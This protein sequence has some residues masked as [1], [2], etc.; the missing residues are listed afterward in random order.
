MNAIAVILL[1]FSL[2]GALDRIIGN[3]FG[4]GKEFEK[5]FDLMGSLCLSM[6]GM[7]VM[8][9]WLAQ[10]LEPALQWIWNHLKIDP[11]MIT[12]MIF[13]GDCGGAP[14]ATEVAMDPQM[15]RFTGLVVSS[16]MGMTI[17][18][19]IAFG[20]TVV[21]PDRHEPMLLGML[22]GVLTIPVGCIVAGLMMQI[23]VGQ[24]LYNMLP[25]LFFS[26]IIGVGLVL[27]PKLC[28]K[29]FNGLGIAMKALIT[30]GIALGLIQYVTGYEVIEGLMPFNEAIGYCIAAAVALTGA[31]PLLSIISRLGHKQIS[32]LSRKLK[33]NDMAAK[34]FLSCL[35]SGF[36]VIEAMNEMDEKGIMLNAAFAISAAFVFADHLAFTLAYDAPVLPA[37]IV[38]KL[39]S[40]LCAL[41]TANVVYGR[42]KKA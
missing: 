40:G 29:V 9:P 18:F 2:F 28:T 13:C 16:M 1:V 3:H 31:L 34:G 14:L 25:L 4:L 22:V 21:K 37:M 17:T 15:G 27:A 32:A 5:G 19:T 24:L 11:S 36:T 26:L 20:L 12:S 6:I 7:L 8:T 23:P 38:G 41:V 30:V 10:V 39:I 42:M 33:I 35:A